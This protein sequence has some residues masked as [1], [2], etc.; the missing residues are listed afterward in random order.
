MIVDNNDAEQVK[1]RTRGLSS[2][3]LQGTLPGPR[4]GP[5]PGPAMCQRI[6]L[7]YPRSLQG[8]C[9]VLSSPMA[10]QTPS[11]AT[12]KSPSRLR[13]GNQTFSLDAPIATAHHR[14]L[15]SQSCA[16]WI[17]HRRT[18]RVQKNPTFD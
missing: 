1:T 12:P 17:Y 8:P 9:K 18:T 5:W 13:H 14:L 11:V 16:Y 7:C 4:Q 6:F 3:F 10:T 15:V 2:R